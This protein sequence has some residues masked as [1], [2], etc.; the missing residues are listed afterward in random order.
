MPH[1]QSHTRC[2]FLYSSVR[3]ADWNDQYFP[4]I[5]KAR[6]SLALSGKG[7]K[8]F[9]LIDGFPRYYLFCFLLMDSLLFPGNLTFMD[10]GKECTT[11]SSFIVRKILC[12]FCV[13][14]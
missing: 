14:V 8:R 12:L 7:K 6:M 2:F 10:S 11:I 4:I 1:T 3:G 13:Y 5:L 9:T